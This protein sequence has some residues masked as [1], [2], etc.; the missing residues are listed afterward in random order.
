MGVDVNLRVRIGYP[1]EC[2]G[3]GRTVTWATTRQKRN[4]K[5]DFYPVE[6]GD[7]Y[8]VSFDGKEAVVAKVTR[9]TPSDEPRYTC[10]LGRCSGR[11]P[12]RRRTPVALNPYQR[13]FK[14]QWDERAKRAPA[15]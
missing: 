13:E 5:M 1:K 4:I 12:R 7:F 6:A 10:H 8:V 11:S 15:A 14:R 2:P 9:N 3:C